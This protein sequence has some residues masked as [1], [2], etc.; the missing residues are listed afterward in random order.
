ML[1]LDKVEGLSLFFIEDKSY[2]LMYNNFADFYG[3]AG[4]DIFGTEL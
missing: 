4:V 3:I 2:A 1:I